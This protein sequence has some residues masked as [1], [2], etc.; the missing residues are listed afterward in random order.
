MEEM[1]TK[2]DEKKIKIAEKMRDIM[3]ILGLDVYSPDLVDTPKRIARM[4]IDEIFGGIN[5]P[6]LALTVFPN[7]EKYNELIVEKG[8]EFY[9]TCAHHFVPFFGS[10]CIGYLPDKVYV[11]LSKL[12]RVV[13]HFSRRPQVQE[14]LTMQI[15]DY[16]F[17]TLEPKALMVII[18]AEHLCMSMRGV[19][20]PR[21]LTIT[22]AI[23]G[24]NIKDVK[25]E[26]LRLL[27]E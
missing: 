12:A 3:M 21:H 8:I 23:R 2:A 24:E 10:V 5:A 1:V 7:T 26:M 18:K 17:K 19:K 25:D 15:A 11:G 14:R 13:E 9:S 6:E 22:S 20:K 27:G 4:Y 16:L